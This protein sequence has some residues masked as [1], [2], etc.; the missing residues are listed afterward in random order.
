MLTKDV[1]VVTGTSGNDTIRGVVTDAS[2]DTKNTLNQLDEIN[3]GAGIDTL[4]ISNS[5]AAAIKLPIMSN[6]EIVDLS[7]TDQ[8]T[9]NTTTVTGVTNLNVLAVGAGKVTSA[10]AAATTDINISMKAGGATVAAVGGKNVT[11]KLTDVADADDITIGATVPKGDVVV[12][13]TGK[14]YAKAA[15]DLAEITITGGKTVTVTQKATSD[16]SEAAADTGATGR[17]IVQGDIVITA[18]ADTTTVTVKQDATNAGKNAANT[19]GGKLDVKTVKFSDL[20][21]TKTV[22]LTGGG[23]T[24]TFTAGATDVLAADVAKAF[25]NL[26]NGA[27]IGTVAAGDTQGSG[28]NTKGVF[29]GELVGWTSSAAAADTVTFTGAANGAL[30]LTAGGT[31]ATA[32]VVTPVTAGSANTATPAGGVLKTT[33]GNVKIVGDVALKTVTVDGYTTTVTGTDGITGTTNTALDTVNLSNG[34]AFGIESAAATLALKATNVN[35]KIDVKAGTTTLNAEISNSGT[36]VTEIKSASTTALNVTGSGSV[37]GVVADLGAVTAIN[38]TGLT[39]GT[40]DFTLLGSQTTYTGGAAVDKVGISSNIAV[41]KAINLGDGND[42]LDMS[43]VTTVGNVPTA[44][45]DGGAGDADTVILATAYAAGVNATNFKT[46]VKN[47]ER[48]ELTTVAADTTVDV[49]ALGFGNYVIANGVTTSK[50]LTLKDVNSNGTV[51]LGFGAATYATGVTV[52]VKD[53]DVSGNNSDVLNVIA[54]VD[55]DRDHG[56]LTAANVETVNITVTDTTPGTTTTPTINTSDLILTA[57]KAASSTIKGNGNLDL[58]LTGS[59]KLVTVNAADL[60]GKLTLD[61]HGK[62]AMTITGGSGADTLKAS[63]G[64]TAKA[65]VIVGGAGNDILYA[66]SNGATLTGGEGNDLFMLVNT[67]GTAT[68]G[69]T[70][71]Y[72]TYTTIEDFQAGDLLQL[73]LNAGGPTVATKFTKL[74]ANVLGAVNSD[75]Y[76]SAVMDQIKTQSGGAVWFKHGSDTYIVA[77]VGAN[78]DGATFNGGEDLIIKL[79]GIDGANLSFNSTYGT[80]ALI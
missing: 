18:N 77:D 23:K 10:T 78:S 14:A 62:A 58:V 65:D 61:A 22:T 19:T 46:Q 69:G 33:A 59:D 31:G 11:V 6:V 70:F 49:G 76:I 39:A 20:A 32:P 12:E 51:E 52:L 74:E 27:A 38:T 26:I 35:G 41:S 68:G 44:I 40:A 66:G 3:G 13:T 2:D 34:A 8:A 1:E 9:I 56:T 64:A 57:D 53:A 42:T 47:F 79:T 17:A 71:A 54:K 15:Q 25:A 80:V 29:S 75:S 7:S 67:N 45:L 4:K 72:N 28:S 30:T 37:K 16:A 24:L 73:V 5:A 43:S 55:T 36:T 48:L 50:T 60:T 63:V 21:A